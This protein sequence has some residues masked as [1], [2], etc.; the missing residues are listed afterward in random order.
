MRLPTIRLKPGFDVWVGDNRYRTEEFA[1][2]CARTGAVE[3]ARVVD[4][5][6]G[7]IVILYRER[8][9]ARAR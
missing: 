5:R 4:P 6:T 2:L 8:S 9:R 3:L 7:Q 1:R